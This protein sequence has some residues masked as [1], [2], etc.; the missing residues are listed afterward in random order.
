MTRNTLDTL[1][2]LCR[3]KLSA[4]EAAVLTKEVLQ[5][6]KDICTKYIEAGYD[7]DQVVLLTTEAAVSLRRE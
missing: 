5:A 6:L 7:P 1:G 3:A 2:P 4:P